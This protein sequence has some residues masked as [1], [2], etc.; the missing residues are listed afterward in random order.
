MAAAISRDHAPLFVW[1]P[2]LFAGLKWVFTYPGFMWPRNLV[3]LL[4]S[5]FSFIYTQPALSRCA[6][7]H[8]DW[9]VQIYVRNLAL[10]WLV[11]G[12]FYF[13]LYIVSDRKR[14]IFGMMPDEGC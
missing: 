7:F 10:M 13:I 9:L 12:G 2:R 4:I 3:L 14:V 6:Q 11:Y 8:W 1:P 5:T